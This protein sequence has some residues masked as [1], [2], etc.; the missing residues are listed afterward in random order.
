M[1]FGD[2]FTRAPSVLRLAP[3][4]M[5]H[6]RHL[7]EIHAGAF[8]RGWDEPEFERLIADRAVLADGLFKREVP[9]PAGFALSRRVLDEAEVLTVAVDPNERGRGYA[10]RLMAYHLDNLA[11]AGIRHVHLEVEDGNAPALAL[12]RGLGFMQVG[13]RIGYYAKP[14]GGH[15]SALTMRLRLA[16]R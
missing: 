9:E 7:A 16:P 1:S 10:K 13:R 15:A 2:W 11:G 3:L 5:A 6:A 8:A 12:Y 14:D 4:E